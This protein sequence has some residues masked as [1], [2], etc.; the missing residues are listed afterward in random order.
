V[1]QVRT[2]LIAA[3]PEDGPAWTGLTWYALAR[4]ERVLADKVKD[5]SAADGLLAEIDQT[6][7]TLL[8]RQQKVAEWYRELL[9]QGI[10][11]KWETY[12]ASQR[13]APDNPFLGKTPPLRAQG[14]GVRTDF[15]VLQQHIDEFAGLV[16]QCREEEAKLILESSTTDIGAGD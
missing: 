13:R 6:R 7:P 15:A 12:T 11:L 14:A 10:A 4:L 5:A 3:A 8:R 1:K 16:E 2:A 9:E